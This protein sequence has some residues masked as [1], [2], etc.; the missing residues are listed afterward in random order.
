LRLLLRRG[1]CA[2]MPAL[3]QN[4]GHG[5]DQLPGRCK[6]PLLPLAALSWPTG[7]SSGS[8]ASSASAP[9]AVLAAAPCSDRQRQGAGGCQAFT[10]ATCSRWRDFSGFTPR[11]LRNAVEKLA[12]SVSPRPETPGSAAAPTS[13]RGLRSALR[14]RGGFTRQGPATPRADVGSRTHD[15]RSALRAR[16]GYAR[17]GPATPRSIV[18]DE[19]PVQPAPARRAPRARGSVGLTPL[20]QAGLS[21]A[22]TADEVANSSHASDTED[23]VQVVQPKVLGTVACLGKEATIEPSQ[24]VPELLSLKADAGA[25][26]G[27]VP[28]AQEL[29]RKRLPLQRRQEVK[30]SL[31]GVREFW[32]KQVAIN[33]GSPQ[34]PASN[35]LSRNE[36]QAA[37]QRLAATGH[38]IDVE[39]VRRLRQQ[40]SEAS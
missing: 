35:C 1:S 20:P 38:S 7:Q 22:E 26:G 37:L 24:R 21:E 31:S 5:E 18:E 12:S 6:V 23:D 28:K 27:G 17:Q 32:E 40:L 11:S 14:A 2:L 4:P 16:G 25:Q 15:L 30:S 36:A 39:A 29:Q 3:V 19:P 9:E 13:A 34:L 10:G 33:R 8:P